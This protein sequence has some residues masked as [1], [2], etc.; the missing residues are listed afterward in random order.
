ML[1]D[2]GDAGVIGRV[3]LEANGEDIVGI[4]TRNVQVVGAGLVVLQLQCRQL[5]L[6]NVLCSDESESMELGARLR[7]QGEIRHGL[8]SRVGSVAQHGG[9]FL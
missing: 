2:V 8:A 9:G 5:Q 4:V 3:R 6:W 7:I 1:Q